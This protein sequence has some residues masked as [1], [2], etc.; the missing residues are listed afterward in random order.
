MSNPRTIEIFLP[1]GEPT[2]VKVAHIRN[3]NIDVTYIP[4]ARLNDPKVKGRE[5]LQGV[6][7]Y[8]LAGS[9]EEHAKPK[10]YIGEAEIVHN[11]LQQH[12]A[13][14]DFWNYAI[15][16]T[17]N[18]KHLTKTHVKF[19]EWLCHSKAVVAN[20]CIIENGNVPNKPHTPESTEA[21][22][23]DNYETIELLVA[24]MGLPIFQS[25]AESKST[26]ELTGN[27]TPERPNADL[28]FTLKS[29]VLAA[30]G[31]YTQD[32]FIVLAG[33]VCA[34]PEDEYKHWY[35]KVR[36]QLIMDGIL[37]ES[38]EVHVLS[39]DTLFTSPSAASTVVLGRNSNG[40]AEWKLSD[41]RTLS[42]VYRKVAA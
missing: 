8:L 6:G 16:I 36:Q 26:A 12:N 42:D 29:K 39:Q 31:R 3:R 27:V 37:K 5:A 9:P 28:L 19:L 18:N 24:T 22:L 13:S 23:Y 40:W 33:A 20:R 10:V 15:A 14:K 1:D 17:S 11:R 41:G 30:S 35:P 2:G 38:G 34:K 7:I 4:R 25:L 32:G 21:D